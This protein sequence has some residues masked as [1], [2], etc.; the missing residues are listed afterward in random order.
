M[1]KKKQTRDRGGLEDLPAGPERG[2][3]VA[4]TSIPETET[5]PLSSP[6]PL[7]ALSP[8]DAFIVQLAVKLNRCDDAERTAI[9]GALVKLGEPAIATIRTIMFGAK[10]REVRLELGLVLYRIASGLPKSKWFTINTMVATVL[11]ID[12]LLELRQRELKFLHPHG[13]YLG[14]QEVHSDAPASTELHLHKQS[15]VG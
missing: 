11:R 6:N 15:A 10:E 12:E 1:A 14:P 7:S 13:G 3:P 4:P 9:T 2:E 8:R 5:K